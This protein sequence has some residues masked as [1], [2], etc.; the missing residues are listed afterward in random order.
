V[1]C[2]GDG[3]KEE[4]PAEGKLMPSLREVFGD[5][6]MPAPVRGRRR[7]SPGVRESKQGGCT[8]RKVLLMLSL[9]MLGMP[10]GV[11]GYGNVHIH[12]LA[13]ETTEERRMLDRVV[14]SCPRNPTHRIRLRDS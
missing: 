10:P 11:H 13:E 4:G 8:V 9:A 2:E 6:T 3:R 7:Y 14:S 1:T 12:T 5:A